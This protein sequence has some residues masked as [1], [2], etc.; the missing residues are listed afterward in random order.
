[1]LQVIS[2]VKFTKLRKFMMEEGEKMVEVRR[3][4]AAFLCIPPIYLFIQL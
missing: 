3:I 2:E 1:M 4:S